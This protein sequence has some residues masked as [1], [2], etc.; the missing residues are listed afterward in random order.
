M[1]L[2]HPLPFLLFAILLIFDISKVADATT[3]TVYA[4]E[5]VMDNGQSVL[6]GA[7]IPIHRLG[8][9]RGPGVCGEKLLSVRYHYLLPIY[10]GSLNFLRLVMPPQLLL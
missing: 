8:S 6:L 2:E 4:T 1:M 10:L 5:N 7:L 3:G 9:S